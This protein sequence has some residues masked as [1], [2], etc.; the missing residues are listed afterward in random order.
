MEE[1]TV[2]CLNAISIMVIIDWQSNYDV[3]CIRQEKRSKYCHTSNDS[4]KYSERGK[5]QR[6]A[7]AI[8]YY[9]IYISYAYTKSS[10]NITCQTSLRHL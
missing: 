1:I 7:L 9:V 3:N 2:V 6:Y 5:I 8:L 10:L 4:D